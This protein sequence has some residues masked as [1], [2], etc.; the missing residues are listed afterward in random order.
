MQPALFAD[1]GLRP[2]LETVLDR[3][4]LRG[5]DAD[6]AAG[7]PA[8]ARRPRPGRPGGDRH[9][10]DRRLRAAAAAPAARGRPRQAALGAGPGAD[11]RAGGPGERGDRPLRRRPRGTGAHRL[12]RPAD[13]RAAAGAPEGRRRGRRDARSR[14]RPPRPRLAVARR[15][16]GRGPG[17]G[18]RDVRHGLR[19]RH[20][21]D[22]QGLPA[23]A[24]DRAVLGHHAAQDRQ[25]VAPAPDRPGPD[26]DRAREGGRRARRRGSARSPTWSPAP[27]SRPRSAGCSTWSRPP[28]RWSSAGP[29]RRSTRSPSG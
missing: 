28:R 3:A 6:P 27:T 14:D 26:R 10:Q 7:D 1:L 29:A 8:A 12:R 9:R 18:R 11:P 2:E 20:R 4:R 15:P 5:A 22:P 13:R 25:D 17:R 16:P 23:R 21:G 24:A 19:R